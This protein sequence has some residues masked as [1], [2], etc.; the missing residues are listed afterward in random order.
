MKNSTENFSMITNTF[1]QAA[2][3]NYIKKSM[4]KSAHTIHEVHTLSIFKTTKQK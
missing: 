4:Y 3:L 2:R 1:P